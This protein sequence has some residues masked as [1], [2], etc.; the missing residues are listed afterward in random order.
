MQR[1]VNKKASKSISI[2]VPFY[3]IHLYIQFTFGAFDDIIHF[4]FCTNEFV[5]ILAG[6]SLP[7]L[8]LQATVQ[9]HTCAHRE[10]PTVLNKQYNTITSYG[11]INSRL[12][13]PL[14]DR[15][16]CVGTF[17]FVPRKR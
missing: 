13:Y 10:I 4:Y 12:T 7:A 9:M 17:F 3:K 5:L 16:Y 2:H 11:E 15:L 8:L 6:L 1:Q 14:S